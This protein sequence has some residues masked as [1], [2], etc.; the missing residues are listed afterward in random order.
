MGYK[1]LVGSF[2]MHDIGAT[3]QLVFTGVMD[4]MAFLGK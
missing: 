2:I 3:R 1:L 4:V